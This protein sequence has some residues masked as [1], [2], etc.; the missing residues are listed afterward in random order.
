MSNPIRL[1]LDIPLAAARAMFVTV[2]LEIW[3]KIDFFIDD[4]PGIGLYTP[5]NVIRLPGA[6]LLAMELFT[7]QYVDFPLPRDEMISITKLV[8][9]L[10]M[11]E[12]K[13][14]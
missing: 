13:L 1:P 12:Q 14:F 10:G 5:E 11:S 9:D 7:R 3:G 4:L 6:I 2:P 8:A